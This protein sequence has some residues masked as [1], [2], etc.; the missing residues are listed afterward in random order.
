MSEN[1]KELAWYTCMDAW[2]QD[3]IVICHDA[4]SDDGIIYFCANCSME[5]EKPKEIL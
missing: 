1:K 2:K 5:L 3:G 4:M